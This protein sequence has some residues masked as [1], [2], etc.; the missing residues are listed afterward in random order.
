MEIPSKVRNTKAVINIKNSDD[1][2]FMW[3]VL[4]ALHP[5]EKDP[6]RVSKYA[7]YQNEL[8]FNG[9][10]FPVALKDVPKFERQNE[11]SVNV[12]GYE[13]EVYPLRTTTCS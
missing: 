12:Y 4:A 6:Q 9:I 3:S 10:E 5:Q 8:N 1:K 11:I 7:A 13:N 2:C